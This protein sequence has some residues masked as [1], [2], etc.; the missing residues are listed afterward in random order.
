MFFM[1]FGVQGRPRQPQQAQEDAQE[2]PEKLQALNK[3]NQTNYLKIIS[4]WTSFKPILG[5][6][7]WPNLLKEGANKKTKIEPENSEPR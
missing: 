2:A 7:F 6:I 4:F 1:V 5:S 3:R